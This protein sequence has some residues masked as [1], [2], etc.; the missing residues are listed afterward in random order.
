MEP[1]NRLLLD[2]SNRHYLVS[3]TYVNM[4]L[5]MVAHPRFQAHPG[6]IVL[7]LIPII[8]SRI[9]SSFVDEFPNLYLHY[10]LVQYLF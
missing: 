9:L 5:Q 4:A 6:I 3:V 7:L 10:P 8:V 1:E 2:L